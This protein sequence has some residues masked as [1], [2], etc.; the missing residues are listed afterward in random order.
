MKTLL[1]TTFICFFLFTNAQKFH[2]NEDFN[3][4]TLP[5][6]WSNSA[7]NG[8][9]T[10][11]FGLDGAA[12][13]N[14]NQNLDGTSMA[15]F[16]DNLYGQSSNDNHI[17]LVTPSFNNLGFLNTFLEFDY[18]FR[19]YNTILDSFVVEVFDGSNWQ[20]VFQRDFDDCGNYSVSICNSFPHAKIDIS[21]FQNINCQVRFRYY[22]GHNSL[23][24]GWYVGLDN[25]KIYSPFSNDLSIKSIIS[26]ESNCG[27]SNAEIV[28]VVVLNVGA[29]TTTSF[30]LAFA[31]N[32]IEIATEAVN[33]SLAYNDTLIYRF[34]TTANLSAVGQ[35]QV[36]SYTKL[37]SDSNL[38]NDT[39]LVTI[40]NNPVYTLPYANDFE[41]NLSDWTVSGTNASWQKGIPTSAPINS[42][43][44]GNQ[45]WVTNLSG[46]YNN[47]ELSFLTSPCFDL[48]GLNVD[49]VVRFSLIY[50]LEDK[51]DFAW[52]EYS[53]D[54]G[55]NWSKLLAD[56]L[57]KNWYNNSLLYVWESNSE[58]W[59]D[60]SNI[61]SGLAGETNV[62][63]RLVFDSDPSTA[64]KGVG[65][66][67]FSLYEPTHSDLK[68]NNSLSPL[69]DISLGCSYNNET[70]I[71]G[72]IKNYGKSDSFNL[73]FNYQINN[74][75]VFS[76]NHHIHLK[77]LEEKAILADSTFN[78]LA[79]SNYQFK[80]WIV[81]LNDINPLNDTISGTVLN[82]SATSNSLFFPISEDFTNSVPAST[83]QF[84]NSQLISDWTTTSTL[85]S[86]SPIA[87]IISNG[88]INYHSANSAPAKGMKGLNSNFIYLKSYTSSP[89]SWE[90]YLVSPCLK[91]PNDSS[92]KLSF[93]YH[94]FGS[95]MTDLKVEVSTNYSDWKTIETIVGQTHTSKTDPWHIKTVSL[96]QFAGRMIKLRFTGTISSSLCCRNET[97]LDNIRIFIPEANNFSINGILSPRES[98]VLSDSTIISVQL[99]NLGDSTLVSNSVN[100]NYQINNGPIVTELLD[101]NVI[102]YDIYDYTF[103]QLA[104]MS[105]TD[106]LLELKV[107]A[108]YP[109]LNLVSDTITQLYK[110]NS[111]K[112]FENF[113]SFAL[114][115][116]P[117]ANDTGW[118]TFKQPSQSKW[119]IANFTLNNSSGPIV[120]HTTA[121]AGV[122]QFLYSNYSSNYQRFD[123][124]SPCISLKNAN[125]AELDF[126][127]HNAGIPSNRRLDLYLESYTFNGSN[128]INSYPNLNW[129]KLGSIQTFKS[130]PWFNV[131]RDISSEIGNNIRVHFSI[132]DLSIGEIFAFDDFRIVDS[133]LITSLNPISENRTL[134]VEISP[135]PSKGLYNLNCTNN[136][137]GI[138]YQLF[139]IKGQLIQEGVL[140]KHNN[141]IDLSNS[142][143]GI[144]FLQ[145]NELGIREKLIKY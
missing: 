132:I 100:I 40:Q 7:L 62:K 118:T 105:I 69:L 46:L 19:E 43:S 14:N 95:L 124:Y 51:F 96:S 36:S 94:R 98:C 45:A 144:Y 18:N 87:W 56:S 11:N 6:G 116:L 24:W 38:N 8:T 141:Q 79:S 12:I 80:A 128:F 82:N 97:A 32:G 114:N 44:S 52:M 131:K 130:D 137:A 113:D 78:A 49:P 134:R 71:I 75:P 67:K 111:P 63:F 2:I 5:N 92:I 9:Q 29:D 91:L 123:V 34:N 143:A 125:Q 81:E 145:I 83:G 25:V 89:Q 26:P 15:Y 103:S 54:N 73:S 27:L 3:L 61:V 115:S 133:T 66:D 101:S 129:Q 28:E 55:L 117:Y 127:I 86:N 126:W 106:S 138:D 64:M 50:N 22:D 77:T 57:A 102:G 90:A 121:Q 109:F 17:A 108:G 107:W 84:F 31:V 41:T 85:G 72:E 136:L 142:P 120:D 30:P 122:G 35:Y 110:V 119:G 4:A 16:D 13:H 59:L 47:G 70:H 112:Y 23:D 68:L 21:A 53:I 76:S 65:F 37:P 104:N 48:S 60:V 1:V 74:G 93:G 88:N 99:N 42:A 140:K 139:D 39:F 20:M 135:N 33:A 58:G 10:W